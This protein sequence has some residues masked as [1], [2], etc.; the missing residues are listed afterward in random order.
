[1]RPS[2]ASALPR[3]KFYT[4]TQNQSKSLFE[5]SKGT[6]RE[7]NRKDRSN[8]GA[9]GGSRTHTALRPTDF[10][11]A[12]SAIPPL[13][14]QNHLRLPGRPRQPWGARRPG[15]ANLP[16]GAFSSGK[17]RRVGHTAT[18][19]AAPSVGRCH[20]LRRPDR[21]PRQSTKQNKSPD[22]GGSPSV[23]MVDV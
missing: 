10:E 22:V 17:P 21:P 15:T 14:R 3:V 13:R 1:M 7:N 2:R 19:P 4:A 11:S 6:S 12:A 23:C 16:M 8:D 20:R 18:V 9:G 5:I